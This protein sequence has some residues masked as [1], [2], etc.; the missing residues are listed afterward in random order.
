M[1][2]RGFVVI[3][4]A[5]LGFVFAS[6]SDALGQPPPGVVSWAAGFP[7]AAKGQVT[8]SGTWSAQPG[9]AP[10]GTAVLFAVPTGG[11]PFHTGGG[12]I[13]MNPNVWGNPVPAKVQNLPTGQYTVYATIVF[14][15]AV[16]G[17]TATISSPTSIVNVP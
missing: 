5:A 6:G 16:T 17:A 15:D 1:R 9:W 13:G 11:G 8:G 2:R 10:F 12:G 7:A 14:K 4:F 3:C